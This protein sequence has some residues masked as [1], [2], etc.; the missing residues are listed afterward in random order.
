MSDEMLDTEEE[1][2]E[3]E[4]SDSIAGINITPL[5]DVALTLVLVFMVTMP[6]SM[7]HGITVR[8]QMVEKY[9]LSTPQE[10]IQIR[11]SQ[12]GIFVKDKK[13]KSRHVSNQDLSFVLTQMIIDSPKKRVMLECEKTVPHGQTVWVMDLAKQSGAL[14]ISFIGG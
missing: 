3:E 2:T 7:I 12:Q 14:D 9:G 1:E 11:L 5:V 13:G 10:N 4:D 8:R 6:L